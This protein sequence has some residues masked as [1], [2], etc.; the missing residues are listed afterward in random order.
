MLKAKLGQLKS[1]IIDH[2]GLDIIKPRHVIN[3]DI[4]N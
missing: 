2:V 1:I 4:F 3:I